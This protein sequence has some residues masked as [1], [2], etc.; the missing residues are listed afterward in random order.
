M[1]SENL[2]KFARDLQLKREAENI[3]LQSISS[4]TRIDIKFLRAIED[5]NFS[6]ID[7]VYLRAFI[8]EYAKYVGLDEV[9]TIKNFDLAREGKYG[10]SDVEEVPTREKDEKRVTKDSK[11]YFAT[12]EPFE[13]EE[14]K[15]KN[16]DNRKLLTIGGGILI[17]L[18]IMVYLLFFQNDSQKIIKET[19]F[20]DVLESQQQE[21]DVDRFSIEKSDSTIK[22]GT[23][24]TGDSLILRIVSVDTTWIRILSDGKLPDEFTL[25][26]P[27]TRTMR[28]KNNF[29]LLLGNAGGIKLFLNNKELDQVGKKGE[30]K[31]IKIDTSG[32]IYL[33]IG[34][35]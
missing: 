7:Q 22:S 19:P 18:L 6:I 16:I 23:A 32:I 28:A 20:T 29:N 34:E 35:M 10:L 33:R 1:D 9:D 4:K 27:N 24:I 3:S 31:N 30:I 12:T 26:P 8:R 21:K 5:G 25:R 11:T 13:T 17:V 14:T 15:N 2:K